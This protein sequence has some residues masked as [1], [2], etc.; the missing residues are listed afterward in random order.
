MFIETK[1]L[2]CFTTDAEHSRLFKKTLIGGFSC[3][4]TRLAFDTEVLLDN[5]KNEK[6]IF[7]LNING[8]K[9]TK[10]IS[11]KIFKM[12]ENNQYGKAMTKPFPY[13]CIKKQKHPP[14]LTEFNKILTNRS[15]EGYIGNLFIV[16]IK[17][18]D[19]NPKTLLF[20]EIY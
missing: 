11:T 12:D 5:K 17:F 16:D 7:D 2:Y 1:L 3:V 18:C 13:G 15:Y 9:Q 19:K 10:R 6:V 8:Q 14:S 4:N 20:N